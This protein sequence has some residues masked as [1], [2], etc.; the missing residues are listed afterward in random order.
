[1]ISRER[2]LKT[3]EH[4]EP[5]RVPLD[6]S[7]VDEVMDALIDHYG[8][9]VEEEESKLYMEQMVLFLSERNKAQLLLLNY[10]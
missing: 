7:A 8:I 6:I 10:I 9:Q 1:M 4:Q 2:V 3:I 5:D